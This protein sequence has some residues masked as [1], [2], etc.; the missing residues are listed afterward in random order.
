M[1]RICP[2][3]LFITL[4]TTAAWAQ[5]QPL[6]NEWINY[7]QTYLKIPVAQSG[8]YRITPAELQRAGL[9]TTTVDPTT[10]QLFH[11]GVEQ[12][13]YV[14]GESD[15]RL[16]PTDFLEFYGRG[17]DGAPDSLLYKPAGSYPHPHYSLFSDTTA[18][19]LTWRLD[20]SRTNTGKP[21]KRMISYADTTY[22]GLTPEPYHWAEE[23]RVFT[24]TYS[25][26]NIYPMGAGYEDGAILTDY[27]TGEGWTGPVIKANSRFDQAFSL[28]NFL[29]I[30][31][32]SP[33]VSYGLVGRN[34]HQHRVDYVAG[35]S[36]A[37]LRTLGTG[38][39][40]D[41]TPVRFEAELTTADMSKTNTVVVSLLP[42]QPGEEVSVS[43]LKLRYPQRT[44]LG[45]S[46]SKLL[47]LRTSAGS[48]SY[49]SLG[50]VPDNCRVFDVTDPANVGWVGGQQLGNQWRGVIRNS[51]T[52]R[53]LLTTGQPLSVTSIQLIK[54]RAVESS[55]HN[56]LI[57]THPLLRQPVG[58]VPD[59][60]RAYAAYRASAAGGGY[61]TLTVDIGQLFDQFSYG[62]RHPLA[63][64]RFADF[65]TR[66]K[67]SR[68]TFLFLIGQSR[69]PQGIRKAANGSLLDL[70]PNAGWPGSDLGLVAGL[71]DEPANVP[72]LPIGR[73]NAGQPQQVLDYL[74]KVREHEDVTE[75]ALWRKNVLHLSGGR[76]ATELQSF[77]AYV[78]D[79][80]NVVEKQYVGARVTTLSKQTDNPVET[81][82]VAPLIN[83]GV[84]MISMFGHSSLD[85]ADIDI[86]FVSDDRLGYRNKGRYPFLFANGCAAGNFYF[87]RPTFGTDW[88][89]APDR[90]AVLFMAHTYNGFPLALKRYSDAFYALLTDSNYVTQP[91]AVLQR[92]AIRRY[93]KS[94]TSI[95]DITTAQQMT[96]QGD[97]AVSIF[98][99]SNPDF[100]FGAGTLTLRSANG[101]SLTAGSDSVVISAVV[102]NYG[103]VTGSPLSVRIRRYAADGRLLQESQFFQPAPLYADTLHWRLPNDRLATGETYFELML[104]PNNRIVEGVE[105]NNKAEIGTTGHTTLPF[106]ADLTPPLIEVA[107]DGQRIGDGDVV[108][109]QPVIDVL[110]QDENTRLLRTDTTGLELYLQRPCRAEPCPY[111]RLRLHGSNAQ[112]IPAGLDNAFRLRYQPTALPDGRYSF[113]AIGSDLSGNRAMP[114]Q[115]RFSV[116]TTPEL[117]SA[118]VYPNPFGGQTRFYVTL[119]GQTPPA[120]LSIRITDL[121][122]HLV[123]TLRSP[124]RV[125][126]N[127]WFWDGTSDA[128]AV[129]PTGLYVYTVA[130]VDRPL[131]GVVR[132]T[133]PIILNR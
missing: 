120:N 97:P 67:G 118:G 42:T 11:R 121:T 130:G 5:F 35:P 41:Y 20:Q 9:P 131:A 24:D 100:A 102:V 122:G 63:I 51:Q 83:Q 87:G 126:L 84:G 14:A 95:Y 56:Y 69:D 66:S 59:P 71:N 76:S 4:L 27:D 109:P 6:G 17:N 89:L 65:M 15:K 26:G 90:G 68:P 64:R 86:G 52:A 53:T 21:G 30:V 77:R 37:N 123:R 108:A 93:L 88:M 45:G 73:L 39:F 128:G 38:Q 34:A 62:E 23:L 12:A 7:Q 110:V 129:L 74:D 55:R 133:G 10:I 106:P 48:R 124:A 99:F 80:Q 33:V 132:L 47:R 125:G 8:I 29:P 22:A 1:L 19:F 116:L 54:F 28:T 31:G 85:V 119:T 105:T 79:F 2:F 50:N 78:H 40:Q 101:D 103:R 104:D 127:E 113:L 16:D 115:I 58:N 96:L 46:L 92:E 18:Y 98:P 72:A 3:L 36:T 32:V 82:P 112:W 114:Y 61:D 70:I 94:N 117:T 60:V 81:L 13:I 44:D 49:L 57:V 91:V 43:H 111:E 107:F 75:P 25:A